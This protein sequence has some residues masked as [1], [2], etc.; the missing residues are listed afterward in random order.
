[1]GRICVYPGSFDPV[2]LGHEDII[3]R[4]ATLF[5]HLYVA[6]MHNPKKQG[7]F[8][9]EERMLLLRK[10]TVD[11]PNVTVDCWDGLMVD[12]ARS[13]HAV[14]VVRGLRAVSDFE[15]EMTMSQVNSHLLPEVETIFL[16]TRPEHSYISSSAVREA[17]KFG[18]DIRAFVPACI[19]DDIIAL[20]HGKQGSK[21]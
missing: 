8:T 5:D 10:M 2:T 21:Q 19:A 18:A 12:Y 4:A 9:L 20:F 7:C 13:K 6:V 15:S 14:A 11:L 16:M 3:R 1:M 17:A